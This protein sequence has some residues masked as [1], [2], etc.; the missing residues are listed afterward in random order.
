MMTELA[1]IAKQY[2]KYTNIS[3]FIQDYLTIRDECL[4]GKSV[5]RESLTRIMSDLRS[6]LESKLIQYKKV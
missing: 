3:K 5:T 1:D 6:G 2:L 4:Q